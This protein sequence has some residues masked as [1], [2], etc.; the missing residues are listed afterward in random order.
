MTAS[1][2]TLTPTT[3]TESLLV[4]RAERLRVLARDLNPLLASTYRRRAAELRLEAWA[5]AARLAPAEV[6]AFTADAAVA[7]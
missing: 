2:T 1:V 7:A 4:A 3:D 6:D 5:R